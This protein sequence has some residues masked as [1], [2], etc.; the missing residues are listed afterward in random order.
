MS[1][2]SIDEGADR[3]EEV[4]ARYAAAAQAVSGGASGTADRCGSAPAVST[5]AIKGCW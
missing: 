4:R 2:F 5:P 1:D 3:R